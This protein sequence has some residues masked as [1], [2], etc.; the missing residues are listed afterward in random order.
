MTELLRNLSI[1]SKLLIIIL[2]TTV[3][4]LLT[5]FITMIW[6]GASLFEEDLIKQTRTIAQVVGLQSLPEIEF[7]DRDEAHR[8]LERLTQVPGFCEAV[9]WDRDQRLFARFSK[10]P[11]DKVPEFNERGLVPVDGQGPPWHDEENNLLV[12]VAI[13]SKDEVEPVGFLRLRVS[14]SPLRAKIQ[15]YILTVSLL[16]FIL[17][18][19]ATAAAV[20]LQGVISG[21]ILQLAGAAR[22]VS[23]GGDYSTRVT[24]AGDDEVGV[25]FDAW[26]EMLGQIDQRQF[27]QERVELQLRSQQRQLRIYTKRLEQY[28]EELER[29]NRDLDQFA[30]AVSHDLRAPLRAIGNLS[31]WI[32]EDLEDV[33][34]GDSR[35]HMSLLRKRVERMDRLIN[36]ILEYSRV[37]RVQASSSEVNVDELVQEVIDDLAPPASFSIIVGQGMPTLVT[38]GVRLAQ[39]FSNLIGNAVK[40][41][42]RENG[43]VAISC[44]KD[45]SGQFYTFSVE[46]DGPGIAK[47]H[48]ET[49]FQIFQTLQPRDVSDNTG[50]GLALVTRIVED[51]GGKLEVDSE[52][53]RGSIFRFTWP[54]S[55]DDDNDQEISDGDVADQKGQN[56]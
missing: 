3:L 40:H 7:G 35:R 38:E 28:A 51:H 30:Y 36:G 34:T 31:G 14:T 48:H 24:K 12:E 11:T 13:V 55:R 9:L 16:V 56:G 29:S 50:L 1:R 5:G 25:L 52:P 8:T 26:N 21:P 46:D 43:R 41:H 18:A 45:E 42:D 37:G 10:D 39:V 19:L 20:K 6:Y 47:E 15:K 49:I 4:A 23:L 2:G 44:N 33:L 54:I 27:E 32:D 22:L 53:G 17:I